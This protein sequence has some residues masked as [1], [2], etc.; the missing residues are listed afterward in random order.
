MANYP[1]YE[2]LVNFSITNQCTQK[3]E[4]CMWEA[5]HCS[6]TMTYRWL[7]IS[8]QRH[9]YILSIKD[10]FQFHLTSI[11]CICHIAIIIAHRKQSLIIGLM[12]DCM[13]EDKKPS[14]EL[15]GKRELFHGH[16]Y[17]C[18]SMLHYN[19]NIAVPGASLL[20]KTQT[21]MAPGL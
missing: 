4:L 5:Y 9:W 16:G 3:T 7:L 18:F 2:N 6:S 10:E 13:W 15:S 8:L 21:Q 17:Q 19:C 1:R 14:L 12:Q 20:K 11:L